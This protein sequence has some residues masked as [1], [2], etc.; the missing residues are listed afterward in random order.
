MSCAD[1]ERHEFWHRCDASDVLHPSAEC[2]AE[3]ERLL[4]NLTGAGNDVAMWL[5]RHDESAEHPFIVAMQQTVAINLIR[6][7]RDLC[8]MLGLQLEQIEG[9]ASSADHGAIIAPP[10][11]DG[12][13]VND[14]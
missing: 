1:S 7:T 11:L 10:N 12:M 9:I 3:L 14:L 4:N 2:N 13:G 6:Y 8:L 5:D